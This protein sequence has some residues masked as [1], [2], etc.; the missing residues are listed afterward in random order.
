MTT[1]YRPEGWEKDHP[2]SAGGDGF[3]AG[4]DAMLEGLKKSEVWIKTDGKDGILM[5]P[6]YGMENWKK[7]Y[8][9]FIEE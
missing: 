9:V 4:A 5:S 2:Y 6:A 7:G 3:E 8:L 1:Q